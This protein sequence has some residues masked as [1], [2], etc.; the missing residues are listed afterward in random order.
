MDKYWPSPDRHGR[1][2]KLI[3]VTLEK[4]NLKDV[5]PAKVRADPSYT[6]DLYLRVKGNERE[7]TL[8]LY[9]L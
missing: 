9:A 3:K 7:V 6:C 8:R 4:P 1:L 5:V 2:L